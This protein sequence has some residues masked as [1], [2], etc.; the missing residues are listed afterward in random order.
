MNLWWEYW[1]HMNIGSSIVLMVKVNRRW[2]GTMCVIGTFPTYQMSSLLL[3]CYCPYHHNHSFRNF[4]GD[5]LI[6]NQLCSVCKNWFHFRWAVDIYFICS[7]CY[8]LSFD[9]QCIIWKARVWRITGSL[10]VHIGPW[11]SQCAEV[12]WDGKTEHIY[13]WTYSSYMIVMQSESPIA[14]LFFPWCYCKI[15][16]EARMP[17]FSCSCWKLTCSSQV[18]YG[19]VRFN[20]QSKQ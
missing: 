20:C 17:H 4:C 16:E 18:R 2:W 12:L 14:M 7:M 11:I 13:T 9:M 19:G 8:K 10:L 15:I 6:F 1:W 5:M 3:L